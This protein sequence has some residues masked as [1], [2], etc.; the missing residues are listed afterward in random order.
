MDEIKYISSVK[1]PDGSVYKL[2]DVET[3]E[4]LDSIFNDELVIDCGGTPVDIDDLLL[5]DC[6]GA[7]DNYK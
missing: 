1:L 3:R 4:I 7:P 6:G 5:I 2:K